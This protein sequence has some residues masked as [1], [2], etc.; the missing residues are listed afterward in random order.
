MSRSVPE[1]MP[2]TASRVLGVAI[3]QKEARLLVTLSL[4]IMPEVAGGVGRQIGRKPIQGVEDRK[5]WNASLARRRRF[6]RRRGPFEFEQ[7][8]QNG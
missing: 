5:H 4:Q 1:S 2:A 8:L 6:G 3:L 7:C